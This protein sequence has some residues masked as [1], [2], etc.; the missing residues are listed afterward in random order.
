MLHSK[1]DL[2]RIR[3]LASTNALLRKYIVAK[4]GKCSKLI[5]LAEYSSTDVEFAVDVWSNHRM[6]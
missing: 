4:T 6:E 2:L 5:L 1:C 3:K